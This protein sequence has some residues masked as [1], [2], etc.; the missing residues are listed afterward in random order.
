MSFFYSRWSVI[1]RAEK[2]WGKLGKKNARGRRGDGEK[3]EKDMPKVV[4]KMYVDT[5]SI[6]WATLGQK[7]PKS[8]NHDRGDLKSQL[9]MRFEIAG[10]KPN[11]CLVLA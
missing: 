3:G 8:Q 7:T 10:R 4:R 6:A 1:F 5:Q 2:E 11:P 9:N